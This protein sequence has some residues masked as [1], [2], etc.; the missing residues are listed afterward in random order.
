MRVDQYVTG[1]AAY[2]AIGNHTLQVRKALLDA[3]YDSRIWAEQ[4]HPPLEREARPFEED[5]GRGDGRV[6]LYQ[7]STNSA[8]ACWLAERASAGERLLSHYHNIT[9]ASY[10][11][12]WHRETAHAMRQARQQLVMLAPRVEL[13][14]AVSSYNEQELLAAG[15]EAHRSPFGWYKA[16]TLSCIGHPLAEAYREY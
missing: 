11:E 1:L 7:C 2:D 13:A 15:Y 5:R 9:P 6:L 4:V 12:R 3:G 10:F 16:F 14:M 8:L